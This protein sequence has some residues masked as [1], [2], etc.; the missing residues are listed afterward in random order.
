M[1][2]ISI[3]AFLFA[4]N[5][6]KFSHRLT[7]EKTPGKGYITNS[8]YVYQLEDRCINPLLCNRKA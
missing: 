1:S 3:S 4:E 2:S 5:F 7:D 8:W 6:S